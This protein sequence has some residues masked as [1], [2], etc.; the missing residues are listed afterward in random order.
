MGSTVRDRSHV[1]FEL[2]IGSQPSQW[3]VVCMTDAGWLCES[4]IHISHWHNDPVPQVA[5]AALQQGG[6]VCEIC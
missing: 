6:E 1:H 4:C 5:P 2:G 3:H